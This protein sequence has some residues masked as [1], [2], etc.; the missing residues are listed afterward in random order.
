[1]NWQRSWL[2]LD[3]QEGVHPCAIVETQLGCWTALR[4][5]CLPCVPTPPTSMVVACWRSPPLPP[6]S[7]CM[8]SATLETQVNHYT[9]SPSSSH[10]SRTPSL[11]QPEMS[12][13]SSMSAGHPHSFKQVDT[14]QIGVPIV[15]P[16]RLMLIYQD[17]QHN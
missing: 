3:E 4:G 7:T 11:H 9:A 6:L 13:R 1:M 15:T 16:R 2:S 17:K 5:A 12:R 10:G 14:T 8:A